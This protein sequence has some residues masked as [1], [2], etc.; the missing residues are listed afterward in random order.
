MILRVLEARDRQR[1]RRSRQSP[2][3]ELAGRRVW[4]AGHRGMVGGAVVRR[5]QSE[6]CEIA[7][8][9]AGRPRS[10]RARPMSS[11]GCDAQKPDVVIVAAATVGGILANDTHPADFLYDNLAIE[12]NIIEASRGIGVAKAAVPRL[13][14]HLSAAR[15]AA[16]ARGCAADRAAGADQPVVRG[17]QDRR[18]HAVPGLSPAVRLRF[19]LGDADQSLWHCATITISIS[20]RYSCPDR[21][22][23]C[24]QDGT[25]R[26]RSRSGARGSPRREFL[27]VDD[28]ADALVFLMQHYS[29]EE[30]INVGVGHDMTIREIAEMIMRVVGMKAA[31]AVR[32]FEAGR[33]RR[34]SCWIRAAVR[35][36][37]AGGRVGLEE[38][39]RK[40]YAWYLENV[41]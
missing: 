3:F 22:G 28:L 2:L 16:D 1:S 41:A 19:H 34:V 26:T 33:R 40:A 25:A 11:V 30:H 21:Q 4:V 32:S 37:W 38:G 29:G 23:A 6:A 12:T 39:L 7:H 31:V 13:V 10:A 20:P 24:R 35:A 18:H 17:R 9:W 5:L 27:H 14:M 36:P 8:R 15:A